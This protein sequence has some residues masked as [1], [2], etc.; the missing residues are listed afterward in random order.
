MGVLC[1]TESFLRFARRITPHPLTSPIEN[2]RPLR[3]RS[4][5]W[6]RSVAAA[7]ARRGVSPNFISVVG[8]GFAGGAAALFF[9]L[10]TS[11][12]L[13][14]AAV[15]IQLRLLCNM[16]DGMVA[17]EGGLKSASGDL[18]N[19]FP[20]RLQ[21][22]LILI[23]AG[24]A[25]GLPELGWAS[26]LLATMTAHA[27]AYGGAL[28]LAQ[29]F[30]GPMAKQHR[31]FLI[32]LACLISA[33][34]LSQRGSLISLEVALWMVVGGSAITWMRRLVNMKQKLEQG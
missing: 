33:V 26:A 22:S 9:S 32:T 16:L 21:D 27:R 12:G 7:L 31:M 20:D 13:V 4:A 8:I 5:K 15:C 14:L 29:D 1:C 18:Y 3:T 24:Y 10:P 23:A 6:A 25:V 2:R 30:R 19:E 34:E 28:K 17:V 11:L